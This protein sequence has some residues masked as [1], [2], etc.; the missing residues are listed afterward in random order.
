LALPYDFLF[1]RREAAVLRVDAALLRLA[2]VRLLTTLFTTRRAGFAAAIFFVNA[3]WTAPALAAI[4]PNVA[5][6]DSAT[7][8]RTASS[9]DGL[10]LST[11][12]LLYSQRS[13]ASLANHLCPHALLD[14]PSPL[15]HSDQHNDDRQHQQDVNESTERVRAHHSQQ[16]QNHQDYRY[17]PKQIH[18]SLLLSFFFAPTPLRLRPKLLRVTRFPISLLA[19]FHRMVDEFSCVIRRCLRPP[20]YFLPA[21]DRFVNPIL[22][23]LA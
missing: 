16:P 23:F 4:V 14:G 15:N 17:C 3:F 11:S 2:F 8:V 10:W 9:F 22:R 19:R 18:F 6:I 20:R 12:T 7:F 13:T 21:R 1:A 5:P